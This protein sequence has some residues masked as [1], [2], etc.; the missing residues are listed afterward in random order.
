MY[1][2]ISDSITHYSCCRGFCFYFWIWCHFCCSL[3][4]YFMRNVHNPQCWGDPAPQVSETKLFGLGNYRM[5]N[6]PD[7]NPEISTQLILIKICPFG[8]LY[9]ILRDVRLALNVELFI[10]FPSFLTLPMTA[11]DHKSPQSWLGYMSRSFVPRNYF[12]AK[13]VH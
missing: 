2:G 6:N 5:T 13:Y 8:H 3:Q 10:T 4:S 9:F 11:E 1:I 12:N 7:T